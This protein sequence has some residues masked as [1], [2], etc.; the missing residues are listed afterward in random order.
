MWEYNGYKAYWSDGAQ[1]IAPHDVNIIDYVNRINGVGEIKFDGDNRRSR[2]QGHG[3][4]SRS[5]RFYHPPQAYVLLQL[6]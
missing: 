5:T 2:I 3:K 1:I 4:M 6:S